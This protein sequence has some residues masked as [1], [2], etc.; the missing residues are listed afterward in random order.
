MSFDWIFKGLATATP[1]L[2]LLSQ[3]Q[4]AREVPAY[5]KIR[6]AIAHATDGKLRFPV[7]RLSG[8]EVADLVD[9]EEREAAAVTDPL[10]K[11]A[12]AFGLGERG[13]DVAK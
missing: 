1:V 12:I 13:D 6:P 8:G 11:G 4:R 10:A 5:L 3:H 7:R 9:D 2:D